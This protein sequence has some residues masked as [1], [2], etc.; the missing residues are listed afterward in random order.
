MHI[1]FKLKIRASLEAQWRGVCRRHR[2]G[3]WSRKTPHV[4]E[5]QLLSLCSR[6]QEPQLLKP[7]RLEPVLWNKRSH[8]N[9]KPTCWSWRVVPTC[10]NYAKKPEQ[11]Q[12]PSTAKYKQIIKLNSYQKT[13][14]L[15]FLLIHFPGIKYSFY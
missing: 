14:Y 13:I 7:E 15:L 4:S 1:F 11:Q 6:V 9:K 5:W 8:G 2:F 12:R 3:P 10:H